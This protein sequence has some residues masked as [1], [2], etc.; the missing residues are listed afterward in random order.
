MP[1]LPTCDSTQEFSFVLMQAQTKTEE[2]RVGDTRLCV[3]YLD[4]AWGFVPSLGVK[5]KGFFY[6]TSTDSK[7]TLQGPFESRDAAVA[8]FSQ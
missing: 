7:A 8:D 4:P 2:V 6:Q 3:R 1:L 5:H